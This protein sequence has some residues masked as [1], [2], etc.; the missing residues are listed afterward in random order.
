MRESADQTEKNEKEFW[1]GLPWWVW[2]VISNA[3]SE[4]FK[5]VLETDARKQGEKQQESGE[6]VSLNL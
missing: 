2:R 1:F 6:K 4:P 5:Q 3:F